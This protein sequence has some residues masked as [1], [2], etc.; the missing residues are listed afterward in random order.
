M[1]ITQLD[2][3]RPEALKAPG[4]PKAERVAGYLDGPCQWPAP[5][6]S[7]FPGVPKV[8]ISD[9]ADVLADV[10]D[11]EHGTAS[12][13]MVRGSVAFRAGACLPSAVY[14]AES[15]WDMAAGVLV[16]LPI[17]WWVAAWGA[18]SWPVLHVG[19][20]TIRAAAWQ[21]VSMPD[22][23]LSHVDDVAWPVLGEPAP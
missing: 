16:G 20:R 9:Q 12:L 3:C 21:E 15:G 18:A 10:F 13:R 6:W 5:G 17:V 4:V 22:W 8:R 19:S 14:V 1:I 23:D 7:A 11:W 2:A